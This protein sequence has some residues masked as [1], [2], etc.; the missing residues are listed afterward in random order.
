M[1]V[2]GRLD[3]GFEKPEEERE[4]GWVIRRFERTNRNQMRPEARR[5]TRPKGDRY[6]RH[7]DRPAVRSRSFGG[8]GQPGPQT[9]DQ[10]LDAVLKMPPLVNRD[11]NSVTK[12]DKPVRSER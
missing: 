12:E 2:R 3:P 11:Q 7:I 6:P 1:Q 8:Q 5:R 10:R 9:I 4:Q